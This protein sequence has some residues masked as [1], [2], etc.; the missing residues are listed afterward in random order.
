MTGK[1]NKIKLMCTDG[2][3]YKPP[4]GDYALGLM[5]YDLRKKPS[6]IM[7]TIDFV[8]YEF[9]DESVEI[10]TATAKKYNMRFYARYNMSIFVA[11]DVFDEALADKFIDDMN[12]ALKKE[13]K[14]HSTSSPMSIQKYVTGYEKHETKRMK[15]ARVKRFMR[16]LNAMCAEKEIEKGNIK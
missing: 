6:G 9:L 8:D 2:K 1:K 16:I 14:R 11:L 5:Q 4:K 3:I 13:A 12:A 15:Q 7:V 10:I